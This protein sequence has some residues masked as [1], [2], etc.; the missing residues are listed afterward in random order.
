MRSLLSIVLC[1]VAVG[2]QTTRQS[3]V[4]QHSPVLPQAAPASESPPPPA[5]GADFVRARRGRSVVLPAPDGPVAQASRNNGDVRV[6]SQHNADRR[7]PNFLDLSDSDDGSA[8]A[9]A[10]HNEPTLEDLDARTERV[11]AQ[12]DEMIMKL[13]STHAAA[14]GFDSVDHNDLPEIVPGPSSAP[15][16]PQW[17]FR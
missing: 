5:P 17:A 4:P 1:V 13:E 7:L 8:K 3:A 2:C 10:N 12:V 14:K 15:S 9:N 11:E 16:F 6:V